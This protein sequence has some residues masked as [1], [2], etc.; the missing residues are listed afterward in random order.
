MV[1]KS[2]ETN[3]FIKTLSAANTML[4]KKHFNE[5]NF[6]KSFTE[7][8]QDQRKNCNSKEIFKI[9]SFQ[10]MMEVI[11][12]LE[13]LEYVKVFIKSYPKTQS[14]DKSFIRSDYVRYHLEIYYLNI[15]GL[16]DR[17]LILT[18]HIYNLGLKTKHIK[19]NIIIDNAHLVDTKTK[20][21]LKLFEKTLKKT[22][23]I[24]NYINHES[25]LYES[26]LREIQLYEY[27]LKSNSANIN[28]SMQKIMKTYIKLEYS[29]YIKKKNREIKRA[30]ESLEIIVDDFL[31]SLLE[32]YKET[33]RRV[34]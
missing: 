26:E 9:D 30:N 3:K 15:I 24:R 19:Y 12:K 20:E 23:R 31:E 7:D 21:V 32:K 4:I 10:L 25:S 13:K 11:V 27:L 34:N 16:F 18:N 33:L 29:K 2:L 22:R 28:E 5:E 17:C 8:R 1:K 14:W 6:K